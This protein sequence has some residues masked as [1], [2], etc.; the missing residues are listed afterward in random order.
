MITSNW[1]F[2]WLML[3][4]FDNISAVIMPS[5]RTPWTDESKCTCTPAIILLNISANTIPY[6]VI[7]YMLYGNTRKAEHVLVGEDLTICIR[8]E[9]FDAD[10]STDDARYPTVAAAGAP[11]SW[12]QR[13]R[14]EL[15]WRRDAARTPCVSRRWRHSRHQAASAASVTCTAWVR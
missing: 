2:S 12:T 14:W 3:S 8:C 13:R 10:W 4:R 9:W 5:R 11:Q 15:W 7:M 6:D 1:S